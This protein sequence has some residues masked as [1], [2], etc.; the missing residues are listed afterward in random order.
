ME[1]S[2]TS[3]IAPISLQARQPSLLDRLLYS[4][5]YLEAR[6]VVDQFAAYHSEILRKLN[7]LVGGVR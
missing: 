4:R 6:T 3:I 2:N 7:R 1:S 5:W